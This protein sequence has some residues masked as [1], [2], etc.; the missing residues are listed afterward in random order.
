[1]PLP[2]TAAQIRLSNIV[3]SLNTALITL[4][5]VTESL[6][7]PFLQPISNTVHSLL[8]AVQTVKR[9]QDNCSQMLEQIH[10]VIYAVIWV[11]LKSETGGELSPT[12]L[13]SLGKFTQ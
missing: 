2:P 5:A 3:A 1:M 9:N 10:E 11:H 7:A 8:T 13:D 6:K 4:D 12:M